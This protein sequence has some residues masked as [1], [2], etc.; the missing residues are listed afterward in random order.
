MSVSTESCKMIIPLLKKQ[1]T[2]FVIFGT[3]FKTTAAFLSRPVSPSTIHTHLYSTKTPI[4]IMPTETPSPSN[5]WYSDAAIGRDR[6]HVLEKRETNW[7]AVS[8]DPK[9]RF[10]FQTRQGVYHTTTNNEKEELPIPRFY[11]FSELSQF[12]GEETIQA[13]VKSQDARQ[14]LAWLGEHD[15]HNYWVYYQADHPSPQDNLTIVTPL[16]EFGDRLESSMEAAILATANGLVEFHK[17]HPFCSKCGSK[18]RITKAGASRTCMDNNNKDCGTSVYPRMDVASIMLITSPCEQYALLGRK[19]MWP[20][21]RYSTLAGFAEVGETLE[22][23]CARETQEESGVQV[24]RSSIKFVCSQPWPFPRSL[25]VGF[26]AKASA[27]IEEEGNN[28]STDLPP[29]QI[30]ELEMEDVRW[31]P[32]DYVKERLAGGSTALGYQPSETEQEF[33]IPGPSSLA[34]IL[35]T[36]WANE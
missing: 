17:A 34:R 5:P 8:E 36:Q 19:A 7:K 12:V 30:E 29:I 20:T 3:S 24:D 33:H 9:A 23:C 15:N 13:S 1:R 22:Q 27:I 6:S 21:G 4:T 35:I 10:V 26:R 14:V 31:F 28:T 11:T 2:L 16:R 25:M 32:R 18:T